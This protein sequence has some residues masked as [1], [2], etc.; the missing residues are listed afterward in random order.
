MGWKKK[1]DELTAERK[2]L[3]RQLQDEESA[4]KEAEQRREDVL[5][6]QQLLQTVAASVQQ[7]AHRQ[8]ASIV[9]RCLEAVFDDPYEFRLS[10]VEKRGKTEAE[11]EFGREGALMDPMTAAG[12]GV[13]DVAAFAARLAK[14]MLSRPPKRRLL[15]LDEP[16]RFVSRD[17]RPKV[18]SM[19]E[20]L[21]EEM[22]IQFVTVTHDPVLSIG[23]VIELS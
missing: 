3:V 11:M 19:I 15:V 13:V 10:F 7:Q 1:V 14:L 9:S 16:F 2:R 6:A 8:I 23:K 12:G 17:L 18:R 5:A 4:A 21:A 20:T 22:G